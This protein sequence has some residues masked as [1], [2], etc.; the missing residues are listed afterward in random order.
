ML[1]ARTMCCKAQEDAAICTQHEQLFGCA[2]TAHTALEDAAVA[3]LPYIQLWLL[4][5]DVY[6]CL[7]LW[8]DG[9]LKHIDAVSMSSKVDQYAFCALCVPRYTRHRGCMLRA[10]GCWHAER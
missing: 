8:K 2:T 1:T 7:P 5:S 6:Q 4:A 9:P 10:V 3:A